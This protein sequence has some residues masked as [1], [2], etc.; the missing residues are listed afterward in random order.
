MKRRSILVISILCLFVLAFVAIFGIRTM[1]VE[2]I[3]NLISLNV[4]TGASPSEVMRFL[5]AQDLQHTDL[6]RTEFMRFGQH[7]YGNQDVI[8]ATKRNTWRAALQSESI[9]VV[10][11]PNN[12]LVRFDVFP[13]YTGL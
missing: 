7:D 10:F 11:D 3:Q 1:R 9:Q 4:K 2:T 12:H 5:D 6:F 8:I 13:I